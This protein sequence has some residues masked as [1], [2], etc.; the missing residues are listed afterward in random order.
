MQNFFIEEKF[1]SDLSDFAEEFS[2]D[3]IEEMSDDIEWTA[4]NSDLE[5]IFQLSAGFV[6]DSIMDNT[7]RFEDRFPEDSDEIEEQIKTAIQGAI[8]FDK[9]NKSLPELYY[10]NGEMFKI[11]KADLVEILNQ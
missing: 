5:P 6:V 11:T 4:E 2:K 3:E 7:D 8:D 9:L 1:Y 10:P